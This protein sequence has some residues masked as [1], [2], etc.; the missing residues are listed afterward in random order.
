MKNNPYLIGQVVQD[1][2]MFFGRR[3]ELALLQESIRKNR[4]VAVV[5]MRRIGKSSLLYQLAYQF[6]RRSDT[7]LI[8]YLDLEDS[9]YHK[10]SGL[11]TGALRIWYARLRDKAYSFR[12]VNKMEV[13]IEQVTQM[14]ENGFQPVLCLDNVEEI[15]GHKGFDSDFFEAWHQLG[16][17]GNL[18]FITA[19]R[20]PLTDILKQ[21]DDGLPFCN[22]F[23]QL[24]LAGLSR[25]NA[26][27]LLISPFRRARQRQVLPPNYTH[28]A[29]QLAGGHPY[30]LQ[31]AG[32]LLWQHGAIE[33]PQLREK[34][35][36]LAREP[37]YELWRGLSADEKTVASHLAGH[38]TDL[39]NFWVDI[40]E[41][42][43]RLGIAEENDRRRVHLF[44]PI[45]VEWIK[46]GELEEMEAQ[47]GIDDANKRAR[48]L[49]NRQKALLL[50]YTLIALASAAGLAWL[51]WQ[52]V[53]QEPPYLLIAFVAGLLS[54]LLLINRLTEGQFL[55]WLKRL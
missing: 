11:L 50:G 40:Q 17:D 51:V 41:H 53:S 2:E 10:V 20:T 18:L 28:H 4:S 13:F 35:I 5:G 9:R 55:E 43:V 49:Q 14:K 34:F 38:K 39:P 30:F 44:T 26:R 23:T 22:I 54:V 42:L 32:S 46:S 48:P 37:L 45:L 16:R 52:F 8:A 36:P 21:G 19:S 6:R 31:I 12:K 47:R 7:Q 15:M 33:A 27:A 1:A 3:E 29:L 24:D 25:D